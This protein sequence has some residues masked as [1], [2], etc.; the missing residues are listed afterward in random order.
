METFPAFVKAMSYKCLFRVSVKRGYK[1]RQIDLVIAFLYGFLDEVIY[2]EQPALFKLHPELVCCLRKALYRLKQAPQ[3]W[4]R[5]I[6]DF[7]KKLSLE[8]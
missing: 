1:I 8:R 5:T 4:Y 3:V 6:A 2:V 7:L